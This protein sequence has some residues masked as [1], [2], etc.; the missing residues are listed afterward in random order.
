MLFRVV[1]GACLLGLAA[2]GP[3]SVPV[4]LA[5]AA[6]AGAAAGGRQLAE[7]DGHSSASSSSSSFGAAEAI[8]TTAG[9]VA[10][11]AAAGGRKRTWKTL[12]QGDARSNPMKTETHKDY[13]R[14]FMEMHVKTGKW[15]DCDGSRELFGGKK[16]DKRKGKAAAKPTGPAGPS[17]PA[18]PVRFFSRLHRFL[19][20][21]GRKTDAGTATLMKGS[22]A[23]SASMK[24][25]TRESASG[26]L[27]GK[28]HF[29]IVEAY[30]RWENFILV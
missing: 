3:K 20:L 5:A 27:K 17:G 19:L 13:P 7:Y 8:A 25:A 11:A 9:V 26:V 15:L 21:M 24:K 10:V 14:C 22:K 1:F 30:E 2:A 4:A 6:A 29:Q 23:L 12:K 18:G 16:A 28:A